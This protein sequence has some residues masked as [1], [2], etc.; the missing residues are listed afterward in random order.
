MRR[1]SSV[2]VLAA[3]LL[4]GLVVS[5]T[6]VGGQTAL[7]SRAAVK[8]AFNKT[9]KKTIVVDGS[10]R[11][12]Y[13]FTYDTSGTPTCA[14]ADPVCPK[15]WPAF[16]STGKPLAGK[17]INASLLGTATG[18]GGK[19]QVTYN[20][21]PLYYFHGGFGAGKGDKMPGDVKGQ[22]FFLVWYVLSPRGTPIRTPIRN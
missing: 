9:L 16:A 11:T 12:L 7:S 13:M 10:G 3:L 4:S 2:T 17:G 19:Q 15:V 1:I 5:A 14:A 20:R 22:A 8:V 21:H 18:A 6:A